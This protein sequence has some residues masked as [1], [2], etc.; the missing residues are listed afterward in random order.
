MN[1]FGSLG[2]LDGM[3]VEGV[4]PSTSFKGKKIINLFT[5]IMKSNN[6]WPNNDPN[7]MIK[8]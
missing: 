1:K 5:S 8:Q 4:L 7:L 6:S 2:G 3:D